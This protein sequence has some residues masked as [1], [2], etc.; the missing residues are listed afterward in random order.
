MQVNATELHMLVH[1]PVGQERDVLIIQLISFVI[2]GDGHIKVLGLVGSI[3]QILLLESLLLALHLGLLLT[4]LITLW[5][6]LSR[7]TGLSGGRLSR[8]GLGGGTP[9]RF[10]WFSWL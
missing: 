4:L 3:A 7:L 6:G 2:V 9:G 8:S 5:L 10:Y 1:P